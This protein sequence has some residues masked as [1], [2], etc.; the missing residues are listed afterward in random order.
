ML[1]TL[2][3]LRELNSRHAKVDTESMVQVYREY[4]KQLSRLQDEEDEKFV[5]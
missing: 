1:E 3:E 2:E 5:Q 4:E